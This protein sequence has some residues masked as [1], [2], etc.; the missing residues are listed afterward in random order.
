MDKKKEQRT[1]AEIQKDYYY[2]QLKRGFK[3]VS[4]MIPKETKY[5]LNHWKHTLKLTQSE[6][7]AKAISFFDEHFE[8]VEGANR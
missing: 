4:V 8:N 5:R 1:G 7:M 6:F 3:P 2:N